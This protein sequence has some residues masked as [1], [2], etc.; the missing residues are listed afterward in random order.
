MS[1]DEYSPPQSS[2]KTGK[3]SCVWTRTKIT[4]PVPVPSR[5]T[6]EGK[7]IFATGE[8][9][10]LCSIADADVSKLVPC[11]HEEADTRLLLHVAD[12]VQGECRKVCVRTV[13]TDVVVLAITHFDRIKPDELWVALGAGSHFRYI[14]VH[15]LAA[16]MDQ[17][18]C[19]T[20]HVF[21][22][23]TG[24]DT[25]S[26]FGGEAR[27]QPGTHGRVTPKLL[28]HSKTSYSCKVTS[29]T[30]PCQSWNGLWGYYM[31]AQV[32]SQR[33]MKQENN[34]LPRSP[35]HWIT[36]HPRRQPLCSTSNGPVTKPTAGTRP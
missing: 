28:K 36:Y 27:R 25:V 6:E 30:Q 19:A 29:V 2:P 12:A 4:I 17:R 5:S 22:A 11:S 20:L 24:C 23:F 33:S 16:S 26:S 1:E 9:R 13:D 21:H 15:E 8:E 35:E 7:V 34:C 32:T 3:T 10:V 14:P 31:I 18:M